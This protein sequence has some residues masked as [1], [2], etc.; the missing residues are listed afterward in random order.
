MKHILLFRQTDNENVG[1]LYCPHCTRL[2]EVNM[3]RGRIASDRRVVTK[4][5]QR[6]GHTFIHVTLDPFAGLDS[7]IGGGGVCYTCR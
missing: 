1:E 5:D 7:D 6:A 3:K 4:G 2:T